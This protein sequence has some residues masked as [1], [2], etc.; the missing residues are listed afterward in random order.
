MEA[1][2]KEGI[3]VDKT[4]TQAGVCPHMPVHTHTHRKHKETSAESALYFP[5]TLHYSAGPWGW[6]AFPQCRLAPTPPWGRLPC[7]W[8]WSLD[9]SH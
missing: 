1:E 2:V 6:P 5:K 4:H 3:E 7:S 8:L 9:R